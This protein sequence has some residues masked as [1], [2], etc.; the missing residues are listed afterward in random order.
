MLKPHE[1]RDP[2]EVLADDLLRLN[3]ADM[4]RIARH[5]A[6]ECERLRKIDP[7]DRDGVAQVLH[8]MATHISEEAERARK[9]PSQ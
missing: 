4:A 3:W 9:E 6:E 5:I 8:E 2:L 1:P 7:L